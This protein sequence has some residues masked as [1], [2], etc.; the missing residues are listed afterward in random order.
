MFLERPH[1]VGA[2]AL[3]DSLLLFVARSAV[4]EE[5]AR[6]PAFSRRIIGGMALRL[7]HRVIDL[8][9][10]SMRNGRQRV[11]GYLLNAAGE[12]SAEPVAVPLPATKGVIAS[13]LN[14][15]QEH[16]SRILNELSASG[17]IQVQGRSIRL[18]DRSRLRR[19]TD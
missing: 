10:I 13:R 7:R 18:L 1:V 4:F 15:T 6:D 11:I 19:Y 12:E 5:L 17:L 8:E 16:F 9:A 2:Q 14:L 3:E